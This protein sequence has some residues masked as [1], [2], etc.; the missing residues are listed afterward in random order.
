ML[1]E[2]TLLDK[3]VEF[4]ESDA[5]EMYIQ[6]TAGTGKTTILYELMDYCIDENIGSVAAAY[7]HKA[8]K[9]LREKLPR[10]TDRNIIRT[11]HSYLKKRPTINGSATKVSQVD[12]NSQA[13]KPEYAKV[14]FLDEFSMVGEKDY[15]DI[16]DLQYDDEDGE[17]I[18]KVVYIGDKNQLPPVKDQQTIEP[19]GDFV[20]TL[21]KIYRQEGDNKII[22]TLLTINDYINGK[23]A[24]PLVEHNNFKR[25]VNIA[26]YYKAC[27]E[28]KILLAYTNEQVEELNADIQGYRVPLNNDRL[29]SPTLRKFFD[30]GSINKKS[31]QIFNIMGEVLELNSTFKTLETIHEL[32]GVKFYTLTQGVDEYE[33]AAVFGHKTYLDIQKKLANKAVFINKKIVSQFNEDAKQWAKRNWKHDLAKARSEAWRKYLAFKQNVICI[34]FPHAMTVHKSQGS[35]YKNVFLD[36]DDIA[37]CADKDYALYLK[38]MYVGISRASDMVY[39]N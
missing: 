29:F 25:G 24:K 1:E 16:L 11:L 38:L 33:Y 9:V 10:E 13:D 34:D 30:L 22:D 14:I 32:E 20:V 37:K 23:P 15:T 5:P 28:D 6:G 21:T 17:L 39:T 19:H 7:T 27:R 26:D 3:F 12:G 35:T 4:L 18:T 36:T 8:V 2:R 31:E